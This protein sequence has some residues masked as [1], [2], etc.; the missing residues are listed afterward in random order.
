[1]DK[2][3]YSLAAKAIKGLLT[4]ANI[5]GSSVLV[6]SGDTLSRP[7]LAAS[8]TAI[9]YNTDTSG[10]ELWNGSAWVNLSADITAV[11]L[12]GTDTEA[13]I[14]SITDAV[15][16]DLWIASDTLDGWAYDGTNW[17]NI[18]PLQGPQGEKGDQGNSIT[19]VVK[20]AGNGDPET[21]DTYTI[22][23]SDLT[24]TTFEVTNG[25]NG[26]GVDHISKVSGTG[27]PGTTDTYEV[28]LDAGETVSA[29]TFTVLNGQSVDH[30]SKTSGT[31]EAGT[32]DT[33]TAWGD[34]AETLALGTFD[35][36]NGQ[37]G[38]GSINDTTITTT[39]LW[40]SS[41]INSEILAMSIALG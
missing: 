31:G 5:N 7:V 32:T 27:E 38:I 22:T 18:G 9:R 37:D 6:P 19:S 2:I 35:V 23:F 41:K 40:S 12:K 14:L 29:G 10:T 21:V 20:T 26:T 28:W 1:M 16:G 36:Y 30:V 17:I 4:K 25:N 33:Y 39:T 34:A 15:N 13:G 8:E 3:S 11:N 24:T